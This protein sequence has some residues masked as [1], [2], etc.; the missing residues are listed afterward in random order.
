MGHS[1]Y[2]NGSDSDRTYRWQ[3]FLVVDNEPGTQTATSLTTYK[4][5]TQ[6]LIGGLYA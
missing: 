2:D 1:S 6:L 4:F 5:K 3:C